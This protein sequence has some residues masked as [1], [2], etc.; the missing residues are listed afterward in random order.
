MGFRDID[1]K[2]VGSTNEYKNEWLM[3]DC[4]DSI[5]Y[6]GWSVLG[7][8]PHTSSTHNTMKREHNESQAL[9]SQRDRTQMG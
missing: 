5:R 3:A 7:P 9:R 4:V 8:F 6:W 1:M 2:A